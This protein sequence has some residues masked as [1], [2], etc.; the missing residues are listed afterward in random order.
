[1]DFPASAIFAFNANL[2]HVKYADEKDIAAIEE[3]SPQIGSQMNE[4]FGYG[5]QKEISIDI[6]AADF[7]LSKMKFDR[8]IVGGQAGN[9]AQ[10]ASA[11]GV[12]CFLHT[13]S[14]NEEL[15][16][17]FAFPDKVF[18]ANEKGFVQASS[19]LSSAAPAHHFVFEHSESRTRF[20]ASYDPF[21]M[22]PE[23]NFCSGITNELP[24][25]GK[26][27]V[28]G[29]HLVKTPDR[30]RKFIEEIR[31]WKEVNTKLQVFAELGEFQSRDVL[32]V[33]EKELFPIIDILG[34][35]EVEL[36][37]LS[38]D[39]EELPGM[40]PAVLLHTPSEQ[41]VLPNSKQNAA[42]LEFARRCASFKA[43]TGKFAAESD[44]VGAGADFIDSP[45]ET[46]G[47][48]D[49]FSCAYFMC[50]P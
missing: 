26:A 50:I 40:V 37:T 27:F 28:G 41:M 29:F 38:Y 5:I 7:F 43:A 13:N 16:R 15:C 2:D 21:P 31:R 33:V 34:L 45:V 46:V 49:T 20:I 6:K 24:K 36:G 1:M 19:F 44:L 35:N 39:L 4:A 9:A 42:A 3:F 30:A 23:D 48:G 14:A 32:K 18:L 17:K 10:Q 22:H 25:I 11:L 8:S 12:K 47:L